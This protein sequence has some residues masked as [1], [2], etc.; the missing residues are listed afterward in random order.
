MFC[1]VDFAL[2]ENLGIFGLF[3]SIFFLGS[4]LL[5]YLL[6]LLI[7][8]A[9]LNVMCVEFHGLCVGQSDTKERKDSEEDKEESD[10]DIE[11]APF[12]RLLRANANEWPYLLVGTLFATAYGVTMPVF[13]IIFS[14]MLEVWRTHKS[15]EIVMVFDFLQKRLVAGCASEMTM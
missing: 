10:E 11:P 6:L 8:I 15:L 9:I 14:K 3:L 5:I 13:A 2:E 7:I 12:S 4:G 1:A